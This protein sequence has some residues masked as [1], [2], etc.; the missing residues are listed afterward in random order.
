MYYFWFWILDND[1]FII[2]RFRKLGL[3]DYNS[4][5]ASL[6]LEGLN[7]TGLLFCILAVFE[8]SIYTGPH[9]CICSRLRRYGKIEGNYMEFISNRF[10]LCWILVWFYSVGT[11]C[12][13][14]NYIIIFGHYS[15]SIPKIYICLC[16]ACSKFVLF[17]EEFYE[18]WP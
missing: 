6:A 8:N 11:R 7:F 15:S 17:D 13:M 9:W 10:W 2:S 18:V 14:I 3:F 5:C 1:D 4:C 12:I 16:F